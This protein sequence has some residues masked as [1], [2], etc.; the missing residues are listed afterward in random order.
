MK[1]EGV[2]CLVLVSVLIISSISFASAGFFENLMNKISDKVT[3]KAIT[4]NVIG[5]GEKI[6]VV[7]GTDL[8][9]DLVPADYD[10][11]GEADPALY[12]NGDWIIYPSEAGGVVTRNWGWKGGIPVIGDYDGDGAFDL[13]VY[14]NI[15]GVWYIQ[16]LD[17]E[18]ITWAKQWGYAGTQ[19][20]SGDYDGDGVYDLAVYG[21]EEGRWD[22]LSLDG[23]V[24]AWG[25]G[26]GLAK[27]AVSGDYD[28]D[29][30]FDLALYC[31]GP[32]CDS[33][34]NPNL[35]TWYIQKLDG[36][37]ITPYPNAPQWGAPDL[38]PVSGDYD[39]DGIYDLAVYCSD[40]CPPDYPVYTTWYA[41][42]AGATDKLIFWAKK[43]GW[44][45]VR[46]APADYNGDG[47]TD[48]GVFG[49]NQD[50]KKAEWH[51]LLEP[52]E[53]E[54][55]EDECASAGLRACDGNGFR[56][57]VYNPAD[58]CLD[59]SGVYDCPSEDYY[60]EGG[61]CIYNGTAPEPPCEDTCTS[62][63]YQCGTQTICG[64]STNCGN[65]NSGYECNSN[66]LCIPESIGGIECD[67]SDGGL[68]YYTRGNATLTEDSEYISSELDFCIDSSRLSEAICAGGIFEEA[69][70]T[71]STYTCPAGCSDGV[72]Q[73]SITV[74]VIII[75]GDNSQVYINV[76]QDS[77]GSEV[78]TVQLVSVTGTS[79]TIRVT[80]STGG[81]SEGTV[82][83][84]GTI[85]INGIEITLVDADDDE[86]GDEITIFINGVEITLSTTIIEPSCTLTC[87]QGSQF[88]SADAPDSHGQ[89]S[90]G[91]CCGG[92]T[93][94]ECD[95]GYIWNPFSQ[96]C[97]LPEECGGC[98]YSESCLPIG[99]RLTSIEIPNPTYC[100]RTM[101]FELQRIENSTCQNDYECESNACNEGSC[102][103]IRTRIEAQTSLLWN[104]WCNII[105]LFDTAEERDACIAEHSS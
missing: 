51:I 6:I 60:C 54:T 21:S 70:T 42:D 49:L 86:D 26:F 89:A 27:K 50:T 17:G 53:M 18:V 83:V 29:G 88:C 52:S 57:C 103:M 105:H 102:Y 55:C 104:I 64:A 37:M 65:C 12:K 15:N 85:I 2:I 94:Y 31:E 87:N 38:V 59:W 99:F 34:A 68:N 46:A 69:S 67:D 3:G 23:R 79:A 28:G 19:A 97:I 75:E 62:L 71:N 32:N 61:S 11:D 84:G 14:D 73:T 63:G 58:G 66:G 30:K 1:K 80:N 20:V 47:K 41:K 78:Y 101:A 40:G 8:D 56:V 16:S 36:T 24:I 77:G 33:G 22:I 7:G 44:S 81:S 82:S 35:A 76:T 43:F 100:N 98:T 45:G 74:Q 48:L 25:H 96:D 39:G 95:T 9:Y 93:C 4:G 91:E 92:G 5:E 10:G 72:C 90:T 13:A